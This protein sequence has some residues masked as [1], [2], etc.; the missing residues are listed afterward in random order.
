[1]FGG[2]MTM[3]KVGAAGSS[4]GAKAPLASHAA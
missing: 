4:I 3:E 2:G 1:M